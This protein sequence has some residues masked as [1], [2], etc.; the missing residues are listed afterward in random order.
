MPLNNIKKDQEN[1][2]QLFKKQK[3]GV[4]VNISKNWGSG[5]GRVLAL[6]F[7]MRPQI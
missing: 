4:H 7:K 2:E 6:N 3:L 1:S 5:T